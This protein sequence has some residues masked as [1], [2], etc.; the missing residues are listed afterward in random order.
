[1]LD[2]EKNS[3]IE[4]MLEEKPQWLSLLS[5][6]PRKKLLETKESFTVYRTL[7]DILDLPLKNPIVQNLHKK[8][9]HDPLIQHLISDLS[10]WEKDLVRGH[11]HPQ[12]LPNQLWLL[13]DW[14][15]KFKDSKRVQSEIEKIL[16]HQDPLTGQYLA[17]AEVYNRRTKIKSI[18]W[19][20]YLCDH[21]L[22]TS[23]LLQFGFEKHP[24]VQKALE[25]M[26][27]LITQTNQGYGWKCI[28]GLN[29]DFRG[30]GKKDDICPM[31]VIDA[32]R[33]YYLLSTKKR[34][35]F[36][37]DTGKSLLSCW[38]NR[39]TEKPYLFGHGQKF[40]L[41]KPPFLW[42]NIGSVL[43]A[44]SHYP[45]LVE[46]KA[47]RE[48]L[49][50][51]L[52]NFNSDGEIIPKSIKRYFKDFSFGQKKT[53]SPWVELFLLRIYKRAWESDP[54]I[55]PKIQKLDGNSF[56]GSKGGPKKKKIKKP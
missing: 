22:I 54:L 4:Q 17:H 52:L 9:L 7:I 43:D 10:D 53:P 14:G 2:I 3:E 39:A 12:Y 26:R 24:S 18:Q 44:T 42:Y 50:V 8:L 20:S 35:K 45:E 21:N 31:L 25:R 49:A 1:M 46:T 27:D 5:K 19:T 48:L 37:I 32:L 33:G 41:L 15:I 13:Q 56:K 29:S 38:L 34:P 28:P 23:V 36:L 16:S 11:D 6:D 51:S 55:I 47:F 30:P 40:R